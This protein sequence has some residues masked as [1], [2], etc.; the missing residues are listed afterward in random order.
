LLCNL[1]ALHAALTEARHRHA[2]LLAVRAWTPVEG[3]KAPPARL[4]AH[5]VPG[6]CFVRSFAN[7]RRTASPPAYHVVTSNLFTVSERGLQWLEPGTP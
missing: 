7:D 5:A 1:S 4:R 3:E 2:A 6:W